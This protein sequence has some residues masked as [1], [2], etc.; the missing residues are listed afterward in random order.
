MT[1]ISSLTDVRLAA[2]LLVAGAVACGGSSSDSADAASDQ[3][4]TGSGSDE[5]TAFQLE[6]GIGPVTEVVEVGALDPAMAQ[7]GEEIFAIK[8]SSCHKIDERYVGPA[9][10]EIAQQRSA[11]FIMNMILNPKEMYERHPET[12][13]LLAEYL[14]FMPDQ[15]VTPDEARAIVEY[16]RSAAPGDAE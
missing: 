1:M 16:L 2:A 12:K 4:Q 15:N 6:H 5:L 13:A 11:T 14:S 8:C 3:A 9:L 7:T 10:G